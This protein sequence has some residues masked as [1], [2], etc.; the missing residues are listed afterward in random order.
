MRQSKNQNFME[1]AEIVAK[2]SHDAET[3]VGSVLVSNRDGSVLGT[4]YNGFVRGVDDSSLPT[5]RPDKYNYMV[6]S[7]TNLICNIAKNG[8]TTN[9]STLFCTMSPCVNCM[10]MLCQAGI[11]VVICKE[12]YRDF[13]SLLQMKDLRIEESKTPEGYFKLSYKVKT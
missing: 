4:G 9:D 12:K 8:G 11:T 13:D 2:R 5:T 3:K 6:H 10:R 7:E 1:M